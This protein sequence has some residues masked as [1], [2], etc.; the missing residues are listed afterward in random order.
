M[1]VS[2]CDRQ[3]SGE[4]RAARIDSSTAMQSSSIRIDIIVS[5]VK[6]LEQSGGLRGE[7]GIP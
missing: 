7:I 1:R 4:D 2:W 6:Q 5:R 3:T